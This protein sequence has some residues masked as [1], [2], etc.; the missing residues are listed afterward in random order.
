MKSKVLAILKKTV[1]V[2]VSLYVILFV[3][4]QC[5]YYYETEHYSSRVIDITYNEPY[6]QQLINGEYYDVEFENGMKIRQ[7]VTN[8]YRRYKIIGDED[9]FYKE[10]TKTRSYSRFLS[11][12]SDIII[13]KPYLKSSA[14]TIAPC[15]KAHKYDTVTIYDS[16]KSELRTV[17]ESK[18]NEF[19]LFSNSKKMIIYDSTDMCLKIKAFAEDEAVMLS[20]LSLIV[21][22]DDSIE[23]N[24][25][26]GKISIVQNQQVVC[27]TSLPSDF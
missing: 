22:N 13:I 5:R 23:F 19:V 16:V 1:I 2:F 3:I 9:Y 21:N 18:E 15:E 11:D 26:N 4:V 10:R 27:E 25:S 6:N 12:S 20:D 17:Y 14:P 7:Y 24:I 8:F